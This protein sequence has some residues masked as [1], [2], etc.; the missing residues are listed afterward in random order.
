MRDKRTI[1]D[2]IHRLEVQLDHYIEHL[3]VCKDKRDWHGVEDAGSD[4]R[5][6]ESEI[7]ALK[8][9]IQEGKDDGT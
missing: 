3:D 1:E 8:W 9:V 4:I 5:D 6:I 7:K 2:R